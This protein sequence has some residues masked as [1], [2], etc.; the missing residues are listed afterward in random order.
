MSI[1]ISQT[2]L[3]T[4]LRK[5]SADDKAQLLEELA[6]PETPESTNESPCCSTCQSDIACLRAEVA[7][8]KSFVAKNCGSCCDSEEILDVG[9]ECSGC[10]FAV[11]FA[12]IIKYIMIAIFV[13]TFF[14]SISR[15]INNAST[16]LQCPRSFTIPTG[17]GV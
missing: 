16:T 14:Q 9:L 10:P 4:A 1:P 6:K 13:I 5:L 8:L 17:V 2:D 3:L 12:S 11:D 15:L 7:S